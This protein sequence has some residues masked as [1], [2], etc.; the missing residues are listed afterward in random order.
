M[1]ALGPCFIIQAIIYDLALIRRE[2][3]MTIVP[4]N[5]VF[6]IFLFISLEN[7]HNLFLSPPFPSFLVFFSFYFFDYLKDLSVSFFFLFL[8]PMKAIE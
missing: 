4:P 7:G 5:V 6:P 1:H 2:V 8:V 3:G